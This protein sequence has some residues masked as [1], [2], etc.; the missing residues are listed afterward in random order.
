[1][2]LY[3]GDAV[4]WAEKMKNAIQKKWIDRDIYEI[5]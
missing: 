5:F 4:L 1:M 3:N 2:D